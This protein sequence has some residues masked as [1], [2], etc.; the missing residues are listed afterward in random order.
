MPLGV[1]HFHGVQTRPFAFSIW[2]FYKNGH[3]W[4]LHMILLFLE[5]SIEYVYDIYRFPW[6]TK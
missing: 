2:C 4:A 5:S 6:S 3:E 1:T